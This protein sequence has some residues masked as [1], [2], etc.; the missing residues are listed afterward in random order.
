MSQPDPVDRKLFII[1]LLVLCNHVFKHYCTFYDA[2]LNS[3]LVRSHV[4]NH[5]SSELNLLIGVIQG[6]GIGRILFVS[7]INDMSKALSDFRFTVK[8]FAD[9]L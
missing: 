4:G 2:N 3:L 5:M 6:C 1:M 8:F 9:H 7:Y